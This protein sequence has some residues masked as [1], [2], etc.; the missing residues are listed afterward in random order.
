MRRA[1]GVI[2]MTLIAGACGGGGGGSDNAAPTSTTISV[3]QVASA[4]AEYRAP[5]LAALE[6]NEVCGDF[7]RRDQCEKGHYAIAEAPSLDDIQEHLAGMKPALDA[8]DGPVDSEIATLFADTKDALDEIGPLSGEMESCLIPDGTGYPCSESVRS[9]FEA[10]RDKLK[11]LLNR[12][13]PY[14]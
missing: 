1:V 12:W 13:E 8:I 4:V 5:M 11:G 10:A 3:R 14:L 2:M 7:L 6:Q 9:S